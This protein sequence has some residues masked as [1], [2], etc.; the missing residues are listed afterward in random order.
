MIFLPSLMMF[1]S[2]GL[3][4]DLG[5]AWADESVGNKVQDQVGDTK[6]G[7]QKLVR[8]TKRKVRKATGN[9]SVLKDAK[10]KANDADD[11]LS[12]SADKMKRKNK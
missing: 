3:N 11:D 5:I 12:N 1:S 8:T 7:T 2:L 6:T 4:L 10:D 9:D